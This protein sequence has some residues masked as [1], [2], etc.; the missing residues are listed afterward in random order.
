[1]CLTLYLD[2]QLH[3][4]QIQLSISKKIIRSTDNIEIMGAKGQQVVCYYIEHGILS[5][6]K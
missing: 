1:M 2:L 5:I 4:R 3:G 6:I